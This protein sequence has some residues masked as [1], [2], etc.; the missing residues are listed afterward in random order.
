MEKDS[1][2]DALQ[3][4]GRPTSR[5]SLWDVFGQKWTAHAQKLFFFELPVKILTSQLDS[6]AL[7]III[8]I[9]AGRHNVERPLCFAR[10]LFWQQTPNFWDGPLARK[11]HL[12]ILLI[13][14][15]IFYRRSETAK[16]GLD[17]RSQSL[18]KCY[19]IETEQHV[20]NLKRASRAQMSSL[21]YMYWRRNFANRKWKIWPLKRSGAR[22][23]KN[24]RTNLEK[25]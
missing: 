25:T 20:G 8:I 12:D 21:Q 18:L 24:L 6:G 3:L 22:F 16:F 4:E 11:I 1:S 9:K 14:F 5:Q 23:S 15:L 7:I 2:C 19:D 10:R 17:F 13:P